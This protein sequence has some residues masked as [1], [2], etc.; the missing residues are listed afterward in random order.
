MGQSLLVT[1]ALSA[2]VV[3]LAACDNGALTEDGA[4]MAF[5]T[6]EQPG[7]EPV[8]TLTVQ[9]APV[10]GQLDSCLDPTNEFPEAIPTED[11]IESGLAALNLPSVDYFVVK[12]YAGVPS[13]FD[14]EALFDSEAAFGCFRASGTNITV[15]NIVAGEARFIYYRGFQDSYCEDLVY[16][17]VR[18]NITI[19]RDR[20]TQVT[21]FDC[22]S[23]E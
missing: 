13:I 19:E 7:E 3:S 10:E 1:V 18:G 22:T 14:D 12:I 16:E 2:L 20:T 17:A 4:L 23:I 6:Q 9:I 8:G 15:R 11:S 5:G 21:L